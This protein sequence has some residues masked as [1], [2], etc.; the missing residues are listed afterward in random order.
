MSLCSGWVM[1]PNFIRWKLVNCQFLGISL[2]GGVHF[3]DLLLFVFA[4]ILLVLD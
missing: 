4:L 3:F 1:L 2:A